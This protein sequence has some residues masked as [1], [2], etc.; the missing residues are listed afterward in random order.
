MTSA[1]VGFNFSINAHDKKAVAPLEANNADCPFTENVTLNVR[2][3]T[4]VTTATEVSVHL[5]RTKKK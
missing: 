2:F 1:I 4:F 5:K 3:N